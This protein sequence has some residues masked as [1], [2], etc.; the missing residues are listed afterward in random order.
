MGDAALGLACD[1][2]PQPPDWAVVRNMS[3]PV[4]N[5]DLPAGEFHLNQQTTWAVGYYTAYGQYTSIAGALA[6]WGII[7]RTLTRTWK[8]EP[9]AGRA[10]MAPKV[11]ALHGLPPRKLRGNHRAPRRACWRRCRAF[12]FRAHVMEI[13]ALVCDAAQSAAGR[14]H[15]LGGW[16]SYRLKGPAS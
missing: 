3:D 12:S 5:A 16:D 1:E 2:L 15:L 6:T 13:R 9:L 4:I 8:P 10:D 7:R 11:A 14:I